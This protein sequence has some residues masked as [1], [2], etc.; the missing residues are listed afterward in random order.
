[1]DLQ[2]MQGARLGFGTERGKE[3]KGRKE[4]AGTSPAVPDPAGL[5]A[6]SGKGWEQA[7]SGLV[8]KAR[9]QAFTSRTG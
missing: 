1:M 7:Q 9:L 2:P 3:E 5:A 8:R 6:G 4:H